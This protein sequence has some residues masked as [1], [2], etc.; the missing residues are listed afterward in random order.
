[1]HTH[2]SEE[3]LLEWQMP[4]DRPLEYTTTHQLALQ[5][6]MMRRANAEE[7]GTGCE[8]ADGSS[9]APFNMESVAC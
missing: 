9:A 4:V 7:N 3:F 6:V 8:W 5:F 2:R 1:M